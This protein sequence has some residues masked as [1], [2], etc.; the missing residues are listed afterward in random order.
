MTCVKGSAIVYIYI[1]RIK[2]TVLYKI[3]MFYYPQ[4][5]LFCA[6]NRSLECTLYSG[7]ALSNIYISA[8]FLEDM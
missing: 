3:S 4:I 7:W 1:M 5:Y 8:Q 2:Q 6:L